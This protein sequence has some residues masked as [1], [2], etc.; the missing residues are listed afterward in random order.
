MSNLRPL[1]V[2]N[3]IKNGFNHFQKLPTKKPSFDHE[4]INYQA[5][6]ERAYNLR[7]AT[8]P[9]GVLPLTAADPDFPVGP[10]IS[11]AI[12]DYAKVGVFSYGPSEGLPSFKEA[13]AKVA[14]DDAE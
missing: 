2:R 3:G 7:W 4:S 6:K 9:N 12:Q 10:E 13:A 8:V 14:G 5:L 1:A 11:Q